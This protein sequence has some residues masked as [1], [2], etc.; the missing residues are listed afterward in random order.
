MARYITLN[1]INEEGTP[2]PWPGTPTQFELGTQEIVVPVWIGVSEDGSD[3]QIYP[4]TI[5]PQT[6]LNSWPRLYQGVQISTVLGPDESP[7]EPGPN[8]FV[9]YNSEADFN[10]LVAACCVATSDLDS[11]QDSP[12]VPPEMLTLMYIFTDGSGLGT[13]VITADG[14]EVL[15][16]TGSGQGVLQI[17]EG[18]DVVATVDGAWDHSATLFEDGDQVDTASD[19]SGNPAVLTAND[20]AVEYAIVA[21][22]TPMPPE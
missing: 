17:P 22:A 9:Y 8:E 7:L 6:I 1:L 11:P 4:L 19:T 21:Q 14:D 5:A 13:L 20:V 18:S 16:L 10:R 12:V 3:N 2:H 15:N